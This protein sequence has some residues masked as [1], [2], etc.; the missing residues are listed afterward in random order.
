M[1]R[2]RPERIFVDLL[3]TIAIYSLPIIIYRYA[4]RQRPVKRKT[5]KIITIV[6]GVVAFLVMSIIV[7][8][9]SR[10][11]ISGSAIVFWSFV[12]Y[13][14]LISGA[15]EETEEPPKN[16]PKGD[17]TEGDPGEMGYSGEEKQTSDQGEN[18]QPGDDSADTKT[19]GQGEKAQGEYPKE[20]TQP[21]PK[22]MGYQYN[23]GEYEKQATQDEP[24][25]SQNTQ[26]HHNTWD[27]QDMQDEYERIVR[28]CES[29]ESDE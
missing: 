8:S 2:L 15:Q 11:A 28:E 5:A 10:S 3:I 18:A 26:P 7:Y 25:T 27:L 6:Y 4:I 16:P 14:M 19:E 20:S 24:P 12:N 17:G 22:G 23:I 21:I 9:I 13:R 29:A 1:D